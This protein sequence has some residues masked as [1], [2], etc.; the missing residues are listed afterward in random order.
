VASEKIGQNLHRAGHGYVQEAA[1]RFKE[2]LKMMLLGY[3][4]TQARWYFELKKQWQLCWRMKRQFLKP[5]KPQ[6]LEWI[7]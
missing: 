5:L 3:P 7:T 4:D 2:E 6:T 1:Q